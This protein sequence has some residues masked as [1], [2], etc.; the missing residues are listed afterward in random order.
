MFDVTITGIS[1]QISYTVSFFTLSDYSV[2]FSQ[3][4]YELA[5]G[6]ETSLTFTANPSSFLANSRIV[7][8][9]S[10]ENVAT[11]TTDGVV[12][13]VARG[14]ATITAQCGDKTAECTV[15]VREPID[16]A[17]IAFAENV[18]YTGEA[19]TP[20]F[21]VT[22]DGT[23][24]TPGTDYVIESWENN[25]NA[26]LEGSLAGVTIAGSGLFTGTLKG[27]FAIQPADFADVGIGILNGLTKYY[28]GSAVELASGDF[29]A[30]LNGQGVSANDYDLTYE[31]NLNAG[32]ATAVFT[33]KHNY[34]GSK[35]VQF[36]I[37]PADIVNTTISGPETQ[38]YTGEG[39]HRRYD[40][41]ER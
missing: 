41:H 12:K 17:T 22:Y 23:V 20:A 25:T 11:V 40:R 28:T 29:T 10:N 33:G 4:S 39:Y 1:P 9:S 30:T 21:T 3:D 34:T 24:L 8:T 5:A 27:T 14:T 2:A 6:D 35:E 13:G 26:S 31:N 36:T 18:T 38:T 7:Y 32:T 15:T 19:L 37:Q 16:Q